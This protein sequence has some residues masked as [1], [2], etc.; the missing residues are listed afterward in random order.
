MTH[1]PVMVVP[2]IQCGRCQQL[3]DFC[4]QKLTLDHSHAIALC[5]RC[6]IF[7]RIPLTITQCGI[8]DSDE[9]RRKLDPLFLSA[10]GLETEP[11]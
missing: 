9:L 7:A 1:H 3:M 5:R 8:P 6:N 4:P 11:S 10:I 2:N